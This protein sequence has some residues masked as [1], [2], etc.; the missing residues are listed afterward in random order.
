M[1]RFLVLV[2]FTGSA[3]A[4][5]VTVDPPE[6]G[7]VSRAEGLA[8]WERVHD[9]VSHPRCANCHVG[10]DNI[11]MWSGPS[12]GETR[13]H[14]MFI[15]GGES[16]I[17]A[18]FLPCSACHVTLDAGQSRTDGPHRPPQVALDWRLAPVDFQWF[19]RSSAEICAQMADPDRTGGRDW[20]AL[21]EHLRDDAGH[22]GFVKWGFDPGGG[23]AP[24]PYGLQAHIDDVL[25]WGAAG[26][27][28]E[29]GG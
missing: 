11:P 4:Q 26:T 19:G 29:T 8:A 14:G 13:P 10:A 15:S 16:R 25:T 27:P 1:I 23:R 7:S 5:E 21:A 3:A 6:D 9:V 24:A 18:E 20:V 2:L 12:Y 17:G 22:G 28:C